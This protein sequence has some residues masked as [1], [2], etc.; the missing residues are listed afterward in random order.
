MPL[1]LI[2]EGEASGLVRRSSV[3]LWRAVLVGMMLLL[4]VTAY[5]PFRWDPPRM[6]HNQVTRSADGSL[7]FGEMNAARTPATPP[8]LSE[9]RT[10]GFVQIQLD[11]SPQSLTSP[12]A[13]MMMLASDFWHTD[14]A[15]V[16]DHSDVLVW[17]RRP[18]S[19][20]GGYPP[21]AV[22]AALRSRQWNSVEVTLQHHEV[23]ISVNGRTRLTRHLP[24]DPVRGWSQARIAL[25][26]EVQGG[27]PWQGSISHAEVRTYGYS[28]DYVRPGALSI[29]QRYLYFPDHTQ[30]FLPTD[31]QEWLILFAEMLTFVLVGFLA[32][33]ARR[34]PF[35]LVPATLLA[36]GF[37]VLLAAGKLLFHGRHVSGTDVLV[38]AFGALLGALVAARIA[39]AGRRGTARIPRLAVP[40]AGQAGR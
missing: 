24:A 5:F 2:R 23:R 20:I 15:I 34:P 12:Q 18:G 19:D 30:P 8:W 17:L 1:S 27:G 37:A 36:T 16:Q 32:V 9:V 6:V 39:H 11:A 7:R 40:D 21:Y 10:S 28:V 13:S 35:G 38:E 31:A 3:A 22:D 29:P 26:D 25:G 14:F 33:W 4:A